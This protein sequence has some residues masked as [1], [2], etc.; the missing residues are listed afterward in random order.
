MTKLRLLMSVAGCIPLLPL[1]RHCKRKRIYLLL[2]STIF[3][4]SPAY[5]EWSQPPEIYCERVNIELSVSPCF[6]NSLRSFPKQKEWQNIRKQIRQ[7]RYYFEADPETGGHR[8]ASE[9]LSGYFDGEG[10]ALDS[11]R[12]Q[13][14]Q[15]SLNAYGYGDDLRSVPQTSAV[16]KEGN[17]LEYRR[18]NLSEWY[19]HDARGIEQGFTLEKPLGWI[20]RSETR[21]NQKLRLALTINGP[22][23]PELNADARGV[24]FKNA[25]GQTVF[26]YNKLHVTDAQG[27]TI[28]ASFEL[29]GLTAIDGQTSSSRQQLHILVED[30]KAVY[31][32]VIDPLI[33]SEQGKFN[34]VHVDAGDLF[35]TSMALDGN[36]LLAGAS[37]DESCI[38]D[39]ASNCPVGG[40]VYVFVFNGTEWNLQA[41]L[42]AD[43][44][45]TGNM[46]GISVALSGDTALIG[47][48]FDNEWFGYGSVYVFTRSGTTWTQQQKLKLDDIM[49]T[50]FGFSVALSG[51]TALIGAFLSSDE[52]TVLP[53]AVYA[54]TRR[55][56]AWTQQQK[57][58]AADASEL[59]LFGMSVALSGDT[60]LIGT[61]SFYGDSGSVY[62]FTRNGTAWVQQQ[63]LTAGDV[64]EGD[65]F[66]WSVALNGDTA[67]IGAYMDDEACSAD[68]DCDSG[69]AYV[70][71]RSDMVWSQQAKLAANDAAAGDE[72]GRSVALNGDTALIGAR[73]DDGGGSAHLFTRNDTAWNWQTKFTAN[74]AAAGDEFGYSVL[75][76][77]DTAFIGAPEE[78]GGGSVHLFA[79]SD[80]AWSRQPKLAADDAAAGD[81]FGR[82][83]A[84]SGDTAL[85][86]AFEDD[87]ACP[88]DP[89][90]NSGS[91]YVFTRSD[92]VWNWNLT[93]DNA[94][95]VF[96]LN[97]A[98]W[99]WQVKL[100]AD[101][102]AAGDLFGESA[103][104]S[105]DM[106]LIGA[107]KDD[108]ACPAD[109]DCDS[110]SAYVFTRGDT[111]WSSPVKLTADDAAAGDWFGKS[112]ALSGDAVLIGAPMD[113][114]SGDNSGSAY[115]FTRGSSDWSLSAKLNA[116]DAAAG[117]LFGYSV[118]LNGD[119]ALIGTPGDNGAYVF[120]RNGTVWSQQQ[121]LTVM[122]E[123]F[124]AYAAL[125]GNTALIGA[126][127]ASAYVFTRNGTLWSQQ[128]M[129]APNDIAAD[130]DF[131]TSFALSGDTV[132][133]GTAGISPD[134]L[135]SVYVFTRGGTEWSQVA[136]FSAND[137]AAYDYF[138]ISVALSGN[139]ALIG[140]YE[141][142][143]G[144]DNSG[145]AYVFDV[146][147]AN[148]APVLD[149]NGDIH[150]SAL[151]ED[152]PDNP[153]TSITDLIAGGLITDTDTGLPFAYKGIVVIA[154][155]TAG[156]GAWQY[157]L[158]GLVWTDLGVPAEV[159]PNQLLVTPARLLAA[160]DTTRIRFVPNADNFNTAKLLAKSKP[161]P[162]IR[163]RAWDQT[164]ACAFPNANPAACKLNG[165]TDDVSLNGDDTPYSAAVE[166]A[167]IIVNPISDPIELAP[168]DNQI[169]FQGL[170]SHFSL[171]VS[172]PLDEPAAN[173]VSYS[174]SVPWL[175]VED[176][177]AGLMKA[178]PTADTKPGEYQVAVTVTEIDGYP[179]YRSSVSEEIKLWVLPAVE[180]QHIPTGKLLILDFSGGVSY[181]GLQFSLQ[182]GPPGA[183]IDSNSGVFTWT[184]D[185][186]GEFNI[187]IGIIE[188]A[189]DASA[190]QTVPI[191]VS[192]NPPNWRFTTL[193]LAAGT[194]T[195]LQNETVG[196][197]VKLTVRSDLNTDLSDLP[198]FL[199]ITAPDGKSRQLEEIADQSGQMNFEGIS[200]FTQK[201]H[202]RIQAFFTGNSRLK[203]SQ[204][205]T[206]TLLAGRSAGYAVLVQG[207]ITSNE[208]LEAHNKT[209]NRVYRHLL[210]RGFDPDNIRYFNYN[211]AQTDVQ[212]YG[213]PDKSALQDS[214]ENWA[215]TRL[216]GS[217]SA[218]YVIMVDHG[219]PEQFILNNDAVSPPELNTWLNTLETGLT[220]DALAEP[221]VVIIGTCYSGGFIQALSKPGRVII[222]SAA[223]NE[224]SYKGPLEAD[225]IRGGEYFIE[226]LFQSLR[227]GDSLKAAFEAAAK[228]T[229]MLTRRN[230]GLS[231]NQGGMFRD[232]AMQHPLL[233]DDGNGTG[234]NVLHAGAGDGGLAE[235]MLL[236]AGAEY[237][238]N[239]DFLDIMQ[240]TEA[241]SLES[242]EAS[243]LL[244]FK[245]NY[246]YRVEIPVMQIRRPE[247]IESMLLYQKQVTEQAELD[248]QRHFLLFNSD[249][250]RY[251]GHYS[252]FDK[253]GRY[254]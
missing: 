143:D 38:S 174:A 41:K 68:P 240:V 12:G 147:F 86:G 230:D 50:Q 75:L 134:Y 46:F 124:G 78:D 159:H 250:Q 139:T 89:D 136:R 228:D 91:A 44:A 219:S 35:G 2:V 138:G 185:R 112:V 48:P 167:S 26:N 6:G 153:G 248:M 223:K 72:F 194:P 199:R 200:G 96:T 224:V 169:V 10:M 104:L 23:T 17:R 252:K 238:I 57:L 62:V 119:T 205:N 149:S 93:A 30:S 180:S 55:G 207:K 105:G 151:D 118:A 218:L 195:V 106:A 53:G 176:P 152:S 113:K 101:D 220:P 52:G 7:A 33:T 163:F 90:C 80:T 201:G 109:P 3:L 69:S 181:P 193:S 9:G 24:K 211:P 203:D 204:S 148:D 142:D 97:D 128:A 122:K 213:K 49:G 15:L 145:S 222:T 236:G 221:R 20:E 155:D 121:K 19:I 235:N 32:L 226:S 11:V 212:I 187:T 154:A 61:G 29:A 102:A 1:W 198:V 43:D 28:A 197:T 56:T 146:V 60:A 130:G 27:N 150:L 99:N 87:D 131:D 173:Q 133:I 245:V 239:G 103:A 36:T 58:T 215:K 179:Q 88:A 183:A 243:A 190:S 108:D 216:N 45:F 231:V 66:G 22:F 8:I 202:Y 4:V 192:K 107:Y 73:K 84:L 137:A 127:D 132:L 214:I 94:A 166:T 246:K 125:D 42:A 196:V 208:G 5:A 157:S 170:S 76:N 217:P 81:R 74:D 65:W 47:D 233:D 126:G 59:E 111:G 241:L 251:E 210:A 160:D 237:N 191:T 31:P 83:A 77:D 225:G 117:N 253:A 85:I 162:S 39:S 79:R 13:R 140:A 189:G 242:N 164:N 188:E 95:D 25:V 71:T 98:V 158:D 82:A 144:G 178:A 168:A 172:D 184:P 186:E 182:N 161:L 135:G 63:K 51:D 171:E 123:A 229:E 165:D 115:V 232:D 116:D 247:P 16:K 114:D 54:F 70:F 206:A 34:R 177:A 92:T 67:L 21:Q 254:D 40:A 100:T 14:L 110:G 209:L 129:L 175:I 37:A 64:E 227:S 234:S 249:S 244:W 156:N 141:D 120:T 18:G